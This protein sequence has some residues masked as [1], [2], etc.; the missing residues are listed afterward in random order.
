M[1]VSGFDMVPDVSKAI[2]NLSSS[3]DMF[4]IENKWFGAGST[5]LEDSLETPVTDNKLPLKN[6]LSVFIIT[7]GT[8]FYLGNS[9]IATIFFLFL[10]T[11]TIFV[12]GVPPVVFK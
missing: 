2:L 10:F 6:F 11:N 3:K 5:S 1:F 9:C 8:S 4:D 12:Y 7:S